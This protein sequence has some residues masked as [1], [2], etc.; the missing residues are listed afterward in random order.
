[1][2]NP[3][4][5]VEFPG[6]TIP[7]TDSTRIQLLSQLGRDYQ[8][9]YAVRLAMLPDDLLMAIRIALATPIELQQLQ[10]RWIIF[11]STVF[12]QKIPLF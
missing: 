2:D 8:R 12:V 6:P 5:F 4:D 9:V 10:V 11:T 1:M 7:L 3:N